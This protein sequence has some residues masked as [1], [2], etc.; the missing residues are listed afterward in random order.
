MNGR[1]GKRISC[2]AETL[3]MHARHESPHNIRYEVILV[4]EL[5]LQASA[6]KKGKNW[7]RKAE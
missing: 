4:R 3:N 1:I 6:N 2:V 5:H 7:S